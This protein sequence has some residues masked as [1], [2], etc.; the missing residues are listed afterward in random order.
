MRPRNTAPSASV[1][2]GGGALV[3]AV[4]ATAFAWMGS[5]GAP[6]TAGPELGGFP[7]G[8]ASALREPIPL[9]RS[10]P[11][12]IVVYLT[13]TCGC[14]A[15]WVEHMSVNG[16]EVTT[17]YP[18]DLAAVK[19]RLG[20]TPALSSCHTAVVNGYV[21]EGHVPADDVRR[22]LAEAPSVA[23]IAVPGMPIGSPGME[24]GDQVDPYDVVAFTADGR[25]RVY[26]SHGR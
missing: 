2:F 21:V 23:G 25:T 1:L 26:S 22:L 16:F 10:E 18:A 7:A 20:V 4:G 3:V 15:G 17:Q 5:R 9:D 6:D 24:V 8:P 11:I 12:P 14:C 13:P 19:E